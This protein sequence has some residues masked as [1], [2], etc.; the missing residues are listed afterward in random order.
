MDRAKNQHRGPN[1]RI[2]TN[3][4]PEMLLEQIVDYLDLPTH[5]D[6]IETVLIIE[7]VTQFRSICL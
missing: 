3:N 7:G 1:N 5:H 6:I 4:S 2:A